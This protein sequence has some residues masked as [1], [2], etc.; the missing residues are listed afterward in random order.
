MGHEDANF[1]L[2]I[3]KSTSKGDLLQTLNFKVRHKT[4]AFFLP[5]QDQ[6]LGHSGAIIILPTLAPN[7]LSCI[8]QYPHSRDNPTHNQLQE[9]SRRSLNTSGIC[10]LHAA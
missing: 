8:S 5:P 10:P 2:P 7:S 4:A 9:F 6:G 3:L 1:K